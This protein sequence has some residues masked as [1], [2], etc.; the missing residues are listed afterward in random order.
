MS[1]IKEGD[2]V[3]VISRPNIRAVEI[4]DTGI[5]THDSAFLYYVRMDYP[6]AGLTH[7]RPFCV[8]EIELY[9]P[10]KKSDIFDVIEVPNG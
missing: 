1:S 4:G 3:I 8:N 9:S 7:E 5:V 2:H 10:F 6:R